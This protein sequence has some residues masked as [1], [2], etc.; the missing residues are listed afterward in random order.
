MERISVYGGLRR[1]QG[2]AAS[3]PNFELIN[4][5]ERSMEQNGKSC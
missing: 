3:Q 2:A 5:K 4:Q 1:K